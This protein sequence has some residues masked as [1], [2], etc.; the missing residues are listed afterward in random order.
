MHSL[1]RSMYQPRYLLSKLR[2][3]F[4]LN[5]LLTCCS[6]SLF[7]ALILSAFFYGYPFF[8]LPGGY[9]ATRLNAK[10]VLGIGILLASI[11]SLL[12]PLAT[13]A[14]T[15]IV[16]L[17]TVRVLQ[18]FAEVC[19]CVWGGGACSSIHDLYYNL[20]SASIPSTHAL[21]AKW[22]PPL[23]RSRMSFICGSGII[24]GSIATFPLSGWLCK[25][26]FAGGWP[27]VFYVSGKS[28]DAC[29]DVKL[30]QVV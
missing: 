25:C 6:Q 4:N 1:T 19:V 9:L 27:S 12:T 21:V 15:S 18:G 13:T 16:P 23:E 14:T 2:L 29:S 11:L 26:G 3:V 17:V 8:Q 5:Y 30:M 28:C 7:S 24:V 10:Y 22:S 20:Q